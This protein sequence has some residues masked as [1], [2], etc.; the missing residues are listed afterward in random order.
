MERKAGLAGVIAVLLAVGAPVLLC[1]GNPVWA[2]ILAL[3]ALPLGVL[4]GFAAGSPKSR[5]AQISFAASLLAAL[6]IVLSV[7]V[8]L[9]IMGINLREALVE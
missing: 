3:V 9:G 1:T 7:L 4:G 6:I 2:L 8:I 5:L